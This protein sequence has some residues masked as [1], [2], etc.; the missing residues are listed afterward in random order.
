MR[1]LVF[2]ISHF[3][4]PLSCS[5]MSEE[6]LLFNSVKLNRSTVPPVTLSSKHKPI[7]HHH[8]NHYKCPSINPPILLPF[9]QF[10]SIW[11]VYVSV[12]LVYSVVLIPFDI[13]F[14]V[15][16][17]MTS[18]LS[19]IG[20]FIDLSLLFDIVLNFRVSSSMHIHII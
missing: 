1:K 14:D 7:A 4:N 18:L 17:S 5:S 8:R 2:E 19:L 6:E 16:P 15:I 12:I 3:L 20:G 10:K 9:G 13:A 11:N